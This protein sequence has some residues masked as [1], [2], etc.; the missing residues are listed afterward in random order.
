MENDFFSVNHIS[1]FLFIDHTISKHLSM[2]R[3][4]RS[5]PQWIY[6]VFCEIKFRLGAIKNSKHFTDSFKWFGPFYPV[7][8]FFSTGEY[9][10]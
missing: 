5:V 3:L 8:C 9:Q 7:L 6:L 2:E 1:S 4:S 10:Y